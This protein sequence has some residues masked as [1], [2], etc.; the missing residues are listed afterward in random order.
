[1]TNDL[2]NV[3]QA[4]QQGDPETALSLATQALAGRPDWPRAHMLAANAAGQ[5][6]KVEVAVEHLA[7]CRGTLEKMPDNLQA[8]LAIANLYTMIGG[9]EAALDI[10]KPLPRRVGMSLDLLDAIAI[11]LHQAGR[12]SE[13]VIFYKKMI[14]LEPSNLNL[15]NNICAAYLAGGQPAEAVKFADTWLNLVPGN[16]EAISFRAVA[17]EESGQR[18]AAAELMNFDRYVQAG[19]VEA[20][21][22]YSSMESFNSAL[23]EAILSHQD[24]KTPPLDSPHYH[25]PDLKITDQILGPK[26]GPIADLEQVIRQ[27]IDAYYASLTTPQDHPFVA[28]RPEAYDLVAWAAVLDKQGNQDAHIHFDGHLSGCYYV[29]IP[30][31]VSSEANGQDG[32]VA[33]G[34]EVGRPPPEFMCKREHRH[35]VIKPVEGAMVLFPSY[36]YHQTVPFQSNER[37]ICVA[38]DAMP[39]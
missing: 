38:F 8:H 33:G 15:Y 12:F 7:F 18:D 3:E 6:G 23:E 16:T 19:V 27:Q 20:P 11:N 31:E 10:L 13:A 4:L 2:S 1:M 35:R 5:L 28:A 25:D 37:R 32:V 17:L 26:D 9:F 29:R 21:A 24:L 14:E 22:G 30:D 36:M 34:F 39:R